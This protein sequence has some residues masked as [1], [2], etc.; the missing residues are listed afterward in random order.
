MKED[1][2]LAVIEDRTKKKLTA[3]KGKTNKKKYRVGS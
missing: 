2:V 3:I 1:D